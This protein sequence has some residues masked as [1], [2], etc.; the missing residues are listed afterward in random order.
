MV[1][2]AKITPPC[3]RR[4]PVLELITKMQIR[5]FFVGLFAVLSLAPV[6]A[7]AQ[8]LAAGAL[9][10]LAVAPS[11]KVWGWGL[12]MFGQLGDNSLSNRTTP[13]EVQGLTDVIAVSAGTF[14]SLALKSDGTV[15]AWGDNAYGQ[16]G[17]TTYTGRRVPVYVQVVT[18]VIAI[19]AGANHSLAVKSDGTVWAWGANDS[20]QLGIG[21]T[22]KTN[23]PTQISTLS[24]MVAVTGGTAF[25]LAIKSDGTVW[26]WGGNGYGQLGD[27]TTTSRLSP[28]QVSGVTNATGVAAGNCQS[29][30]VLS[31]GAVKAWGC[32]GWGQLGDG[33]SDTRTSPVTLSGISS[34][35]AVSAGFAHS[36]AVKT[37]GTAWAWGYNGYG[38][39][40]TGSFTAANVPTAIAGLANISAID[41]GEHYGAAV[42]TNG[43]VW[44]WGANDQGQLG[45][46]TT[47]NRT[48]PGAISDPGMVWTTAMPA[49][50]VTPG[51]YSQVLNVTV[52][53]ATPGAVIHYS[54]DGTQ[55]TDAYPIASGA[56]TINQSMT[57]KA[58]AWHATLAPG[59]TNVAA[60]TLAVSSPS[61]S[62]G[63]GAY[64]SAQT[65]TMTSS[66]AGAVIR[67]TTDGSTPTEFSPAY[68]AA[69]SVSQPMTIKAAAYKTGWTTSSVTTAG[70]GFTNYQ[71]AAPTIT[72]EGGTYDIATVAVSIAP[73]SSQPNRVTAYSTNGNPP[74]TGYWGPFEIDR[75]TTVKSQ[76]AEFQ[77][78][79]GWTYGPITTQLIVVKV[80]G[81]GIDLPSGEYEP[82]T[83]IHVTGGTSNAV[84]RYRLD[85]QTPSDSDPQVPSDGTLM[86]GNFTLAVRAFYQH[87]DPSDVATVTYAVPGTYNSG[88][89]AA[90]REHSVALMPD[91]TVWTWGSNT[92]GQLGYGHRWKANI[93]TGQS[94]SEVVVPTATSPQR[95]SLTGVKAIAAGADFTMALRHDGTVWTWGSNYYGELGRSTC[96]VGYE[97]V[98]KCVR[99]ATVAITDIVAIAAGGLHGLA[100]AADGTV[101]A[102]GRNSNGQLGDGS[103]TD[104]ATPQAISGLSDVIAIAAGYEHSLA[105]KADGT[106]WA[107]G[108][109]WSGQIGDGTG[110]DAN[111][112]HEPVHLATLSNVVRISAGQYHS[113]AIDANGDLW[114]WGHGSS[115]QI[116]NGTTNGTNTPWVALSDV[117]QA[118]GGGSH[119]IAVKNDGS[120]WA[121][122]ANDQGQL[123][124]GTVTQRLIPTLAAM[125]I[126]TRLV[127]AGAS[128]SFAIGTDGSGFA[129]GE[130][131]NGEVGNGTTLDQT[132]PV[133]ILSPGTFGCTYVISPPIT[134][135]DAD[136]HTFEI[137][138]STSPGCG[139][140]AVSESAFITV[141]GTSAT[142]GDG[143][144]TLS[145]PANTDADPRTG[146]VAIA[147]DAVVVTQLGTSGELP[148]DDEVEAP[149]A[150]VSEE[151][152]LELGEVASQ[153]EAALQPSFNEAG[154][155]TNTRYINQKLTFVDAA[156]QLASAA[157]VRLIVYQDPTSGGHFC[158][159]EIQNSCT[160]T[161]DAMDSAHSLV[162]ISPTTCYT[163]AT[164]SCTVTIQTQLLGGT[165]W[166][167]AEVL[168]GPAA[169]RLLRMFRFNRIG[170]NPG[171]A[172]FPA[173]PESDDY[174]LIG[175]TETHPSNHYGTAS[176]I[177]KL[178]RLAADYHARWPELEVLCFNDMSLIRG[179]VFDFQNTWAPP[180]AEHQIG[181]NADLRTLRGPKQ[182]CRTGIPVANP[183]VRTWFKTE[184]F[185]IFGHRDHCLEYPL[186][187]TDQHYHL[188]DLERENKRA[189]CAAY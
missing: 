27:G 4:S 111:D 48:T 134:T 20:G 186:S 140:S 96:D 120:V 23:V 159:R 123:G 116:G 177:A 155:V 39:L 139:W 70:F 83:L 122:G 45:N 66:T 109:N 9:H 100:L 81:P 169:G 172:P 94:E 156:G 61:I 33:T 142:S 35:S 125:P 24:S 8:K 144:V 128:H 85:G 174:K 147:D 47:A 138:V 57:L 54:T 90:G 73:V 56:I 12:N 106:V 143:T 43:V 6:P 87:M 188:R 15:W 18:N 69:F 37:D 149:A 5:R 137:S 78:Y 10:T 165:F 46:G 58:R 13:V 102:W 59:G 2:V 29:L 104:R 112:R 129:W 178:Q 103:T 53:S 44:T 151:Q 126:G 99:P 157:T 62:P 115:G 77:P 16:L 98:A 92:A 64:A 93:Y 107:W 63:G 182:G 19:G 49:F 150:E 183:E 50:S 145:V 164:S 52:S 170:V 1:L 22:T 91:G 152:V 130:N 153:A 171:A 117:A 160:T 148:S 179:G 108:D 189:R 187:T 80:A 154:Y 32:N 60:Y 68:T 31:T 30:A 176:F 17:D 34:V 162:T 173:L 181:K 89:V 14:H 75:T 158:A 118:A 105:L 175:E 131:L 11:G 38:N 36:F 185:N 97:S 25:S 168:D 76:T 114:A 133:Q 7:F 55:P 135:V 95:K 121:W 51:T 72:P 67:Y 74:Y 101:W 42:T 163:G 161:H 71:P 40:G 3:S 141:V 184:L 146:F 119:T 84:I 41:A 127:A 180:H 86:V 82:G 136:S 124:D 88:A 79:V 110:G 65:V 26:S 132:S 113:L 167:G 21:T 166:L 28:V